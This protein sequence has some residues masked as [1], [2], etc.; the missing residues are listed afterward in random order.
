[1]PIETTPTSFTPITRTACTSTRTPIPAPPHVDSHTDEHT[2]G[3]RSPGHVDL[4]AHTD[5]THVDVDHSDF[6]GDS[7]ALGSARHVDTHGDSGR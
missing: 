1:M 5:I 4:D 3:V 6:H 7:G 2:D